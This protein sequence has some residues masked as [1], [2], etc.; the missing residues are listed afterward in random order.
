MLSFGPGVG[1]PVHYEM[2]ICVIVSTE[3]KKWYVLIHDL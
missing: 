2:L 1:L 3:E